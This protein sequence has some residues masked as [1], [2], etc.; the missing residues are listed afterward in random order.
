[1]DSTSSADVSH[2]TDGEITAVDS[3]L[4]SLLTDKFARWRKRRMPQ[5]QKFLNFYQDYMRIPRDGDT[6]GTGLARASK[7]KT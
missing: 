3:R 4:E 1:M 2:E 6:K 5:E 7:A